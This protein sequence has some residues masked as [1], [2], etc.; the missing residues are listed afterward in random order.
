MLS[1]LADHGLRPSRA[2]GQNF[3][4][5]PNTVERI[6]RM[7]RVGV[8][9]HVV[10]IGAGL[11][12]LTIALSGTGAKVTAV[13]VDRGL[14][15]VLEEVVAPLGV[16]VVCADAMSCDWG[17]ILAASSSWVLVANLPYNIATP[18]VLE[19]LAGVP[20]VRRMLVMVQREVG[21]RF[22]AAPR[23]PG[24]GAVSVRIGYFATAAVAGRVPASVFVPRPRVESVLV[25]LE[26]RASPPVDLSV[27]SYEEISELVRLGFAGRRKMLR[28]ALDGVV[29]QAVFRAADID[30]TRR[31]EELTI[32]EWGKLVECRRATMSGP[33][34]S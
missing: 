5:D 31:A 23:Q 10:E 16:E 1:L 27:A 21:E 2:L 14:F 34:R 9:D 12:S 30:G 17:E 26:R 19:L 28:R 22:V 6:A 18:L 8:L 25:S 20:V 32:E 33:T 24:F 7:A 4:A 11:G 13:E 29:D 3:V 15:R